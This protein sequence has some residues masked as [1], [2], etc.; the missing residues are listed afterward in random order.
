MTQDCKAKF[1]QKLVSEH[2]EAMQIASAGALFMKKA[3]DH[4]LE[5]GLPDKK[6]PYYPYFPFTKF[7]ENSFLEK[8]YPRDI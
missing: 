4:F 1:L 8:N 3:F 5:M 7:Y 6:H 2:Q